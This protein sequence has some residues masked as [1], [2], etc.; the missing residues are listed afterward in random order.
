MDEDRGELFITLQ[1]QN[2]KKLR[3]ISLKGS[4]GIDS[5][6]DGALELADS[7]FQIFTEY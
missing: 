3:S 6:Y 1:Q 2:I 4:D 5:S 7:T